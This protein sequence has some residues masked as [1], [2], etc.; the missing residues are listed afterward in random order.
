MRVRTGHRTTTGVYRGGPEVDDAR[1][2]TSRDVF[3]PEHPHMNIAPNPNVSRAS[4]ESGLHAIDGLD[5]PAGVANAADQLAAIASSMRNGTRSGLSQ[6]EVGLLQS[7]LSNIEDEQRTAANVYLAL[8]KPLAPGEKTP[9][10]ADGVQRTMNVFA[11]PGRQQSASAAQLGVL[12][13]TSPRLASRDEALAKVDE[14]VELLRTSIDRT[15]V[16]QADLRAA[17]GGA[18]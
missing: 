16:I 1:T 5:G 10:G 18:S 12:L 13:L 17:L 15:H 11:E 3:Q 7:Q 2:R 4:I 8:F 9:T 14:S 6:S